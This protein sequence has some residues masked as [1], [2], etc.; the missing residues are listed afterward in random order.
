MEG[1]E[2]A[3]RTDAIAE[4]RDEGQMSALC[5]AGPAARDRFVVFRVVLPR[6]TDD[7]GF[8]GWLASRI[9][10]ATGNGLIVVCGQN[11]DRGGVFDYYGIPDIAADAVRAR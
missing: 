8:V 7:S 10:A 2:A 3:G 5:P 9:K 1:E 6:R 4:I 11:R